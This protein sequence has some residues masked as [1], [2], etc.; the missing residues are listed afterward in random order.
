MGL[1]ESHIFIS[2]E[3]T[4][5]KVLKERHSLTP[6]GSSLIPSTLLQHSFGCP[7]VFWVTPF[8]FL[9]GGPWTVSCTT[10]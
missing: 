6:R 4:K 2:T 3:R 8:S 7:L 1:C 10:M 5:L 9:D